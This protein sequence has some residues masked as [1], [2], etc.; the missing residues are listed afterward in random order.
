MMDETVKRQDPAAFLANKKGNGAQQESHEEEPSSTATPITVEPSRNA[1]DSR[2]MECTL[3]AQ[4]LTQLIDKFM[5]AIA[6]EAHVA[7]GQPEP[8][9]QKIKA[10]Q[11]QH[12]SSTVDE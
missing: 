12:M 9:E 3:R 8:T 7:V 5:S 11:S 1:R 4:R 2:K 6:P 10:L